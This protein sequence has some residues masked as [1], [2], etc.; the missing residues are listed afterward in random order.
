MEAELGEEHYLYALSLPIL[1]DFK[2]YPNESAT[3]GIDGGYLRSW[4]NKK[5]NFE[6]IVGKSILKN[7]AND[8]VF[9]F[10][11]GYD[12]KSKRRL[13]ELLVSRDPI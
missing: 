10:V 8:K 9:G 4:E 6:V 5:K 7:R 12:K 2:A 13:H 1:M 3:V 11:Q